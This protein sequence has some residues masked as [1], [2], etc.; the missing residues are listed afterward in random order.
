VKIKEVDCGTFIWGGEME[1]YRLL[2]RS[3][4]SPARPSDSIMK[5]KMYERGV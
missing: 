5:M 1:Q 4:A 3:Q 2:E